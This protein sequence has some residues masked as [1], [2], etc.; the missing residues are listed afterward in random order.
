MCI[1]DR[2]V[3]GG[4]PD[5]RLEGLAAVERQAGQEV[6]G[7]DQEV[8]DAHLEG[9][10]PGQGTGLGHGEGGQAG[11]AE[12]GRDGRSGQGDGRGGARAMG[13]AVH[14]GEAAEGVEVDLAHP[15]P[16]AQA[17]QGVA[18]LVEEDRGEQR[19]REERGDEVGGALADAGDRAA[20]DRRVDGDDHGGEQQP[21]VAEHDGDAAEAAQGEPGAAE[22][23]HALLGTHESPGRPDDVVMSAMKATGEAGPAGPGTM[24]RRSQAAAVGAQTAR[25]WP[26]GLRPA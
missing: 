10:L 20:H 2:P 16:R 25:T 6:V 23:R 17:H 22:R 5:G 15:Y 12:D 19:E 14:L 24:P 21:G 26:C 3:A 7:G 9:Q 1:R 4:R 18:E 8:G 11:E 13:L